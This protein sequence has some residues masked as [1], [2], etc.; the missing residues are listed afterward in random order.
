MKN[1]QALSQDK[2]KQNIFFINLVSRQHFISST[3]IPLSLI[4]N[5]NNSWY[6]FVS[7]QFSILIWIS[8]LWHLTE[9]DIYFAMVWVVLLICICFYHVEFEIAFLQHLL[10]FISCPERFYANFGFMFTQEFVWALEHQREIHSEHW[11]F[12]GHWLIVGRIVISFTFVASRNLSEMKWNIQ[13]YPRY[14]NVH[15]PFSRL[16]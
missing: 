4:S 3:W 2:Q 10:Y 8:N 15:H 5:H 13:K 7:L 6:L 11:A 16:F 14:I 9:P 1:T 12:S